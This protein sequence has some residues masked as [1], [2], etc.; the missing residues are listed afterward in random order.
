MVLGNRTFT[1]GEQRIQMPNFEDNKD[2]V[3]EQRTY[4]N[5]FYVN[6]VGVGEAAR[7]LISGEQGSGYYM[8]HVCKVTWMRT[9]SKAFMIKKPRYMYLIPSE[10]CIRMLHLHVC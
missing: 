8:C 4:K 2:N 1:S 3:E 5:I 9:L 7:Q 10:V 6:R